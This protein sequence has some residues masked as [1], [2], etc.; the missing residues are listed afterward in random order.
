MQTT[1]QPRNQATEQPSNQATEQPRNQVTK[2]PSNQN[3]E[4]SQ[5]IYER[6][7]F[8]MNIFLHCMVYKPLLAISAKKIRCVL[9]FIS[10]YI[11]IATFTTF[12][13]SKERFL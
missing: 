5:Y 7:N 11:I 9:F 3:I 12:V 10:I 13:L 4:T 6:I 8:N 2:Q 1:E